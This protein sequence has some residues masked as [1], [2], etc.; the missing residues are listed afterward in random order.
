MLIFHNRFVCTSLGAG[1]GCLAKFL[2]SEPSLAA[3]NCPPRLAVI[4]ATDVSQSVWRHN[5]EDIASLGDSRCRP[6]ECRLLL[7]QLATPPG[8]AGCGVPCT[9]PATGAS[10]QSVR[11]CTSDVRRACRACALRAAAAMVIGN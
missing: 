2:A 4:D 8:Y 3:P 9:L 10:V 5:H 11:D 7:L 6:R 1:Y